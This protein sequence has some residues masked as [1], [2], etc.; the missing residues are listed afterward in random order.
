MAAE[1]SD[2]RVTDAETVAASAAGEPSAPTS[3]ARDNAPAQYGSPR[4]DPVTAQD[5]DGKTLPSVLS[6][7]MTII[8][9]VRSTGPLTI[10]GRIEGSVDCDDLS[11]G[12]TGRIEGEIRSVSLQIEGAFEGEA[13]CSALEMGPKASFKGNLTCKSMALAFGAIVSGDVKVG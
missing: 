11:V 2:T 12:P 4:K 1:E 5:D 3:V 10:E 9:E 7:G 6:R 13:K 8:G